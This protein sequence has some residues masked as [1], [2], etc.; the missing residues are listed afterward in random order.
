MG[1]QSAF[2]KKKGLCS[3]TIVGGGDP[4]GSLVGLASLGTSG[5]GCDEKSRLGT[6]S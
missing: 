5:V 4:S 3:M 2:D 6:C 1:R